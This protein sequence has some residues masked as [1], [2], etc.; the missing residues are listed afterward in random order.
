MTKNIQKSPEEGK[1]VDQFVSKSVKK[2][3]PKSPFSRV[4]EKYEHLLDSQVVEK[5]MRL[6]R[7]VI[8]ECIKRVSGISSVEYQRTLRNIMAQK[9]IFH[10]PFLK[11]C[12]YLGLQPFEAAQNIVMLSKANR[13]LKEGLENVFKRET[14]MLSDVV[15]TESELAKAK[16]ATPASATT[17]EQESELSVFIERAMSILPTE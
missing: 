9:L 16:Y 11:E 1:T 2:R 3:S 13:V 12:R 5:D 4:N 10:F 8:D 15:F 6:K 17:P 14:D 7:L